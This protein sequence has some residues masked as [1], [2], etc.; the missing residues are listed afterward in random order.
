MGCEVSANLHHAE[1][2]RRDA[3]I[4][5][6]LEG[7]RA[8]RFGAAPLRPEPRAWRRGGLASRHRDRHRQYRR[9]LHGSGRVYSPPAPM[10]GHRR[11][12]AR[13][14][15]AACRGP[16]ARG[17][18]AAFRVAE[19]RSASERHVG[20]ESA[21]DSAAET[22]RAARVAR[23][24]CR[25]GVELEARRR[26]LRISL[27]ACAASALPSGRRAASRAGCSS[28]TSAKACTARAS[29]EGK[30]LGE[31][32]VRRPSRCER[33]ERVSAPRDRARQRRTTDA[34]SIHVAGEDLGGARGPRG[35][36]RRRCARR[37]RLGVPS[38]RALAE[39]VARSRNGALAWC[40]RCR[41]LE[42]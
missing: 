22:Q 7:R 9:V 26:R 29:D 15:R 33:R 10:S 40:A 13:A 28:A 38:V 30:R 5:L 41:G 2:A 11:W 17:A 8:L 12:R 32:R 35:A 6:V 18:A 37:R 31:W 27:L 39:T 14:A 20:R 19:Q 36:A 34:S 24:P 1:A 3:A 4:E 42:D 16:G 25:A 23:D 21:P